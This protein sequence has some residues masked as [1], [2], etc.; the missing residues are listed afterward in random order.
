MC[1]LTSY[2]SLPVGSAK[3]SYINCFHAGGADRR[4]AQVGI[5]VGAAKARF[6]PKAASRFQKDV[7]GGFLASDFLAGDNGAK[8]TPNPY[9]GKNLLD[10]GLESAG[11]NGHGDAPFMLASDGHDLFNGTDQVHEFEVGMLFFFRDRERIDVES[12]FRAQHGQDIARRHAAQLVKAF[13]GENDSMP[14]RDGAPGLPMQGHGVGQ[15]AVAVKDQAVGRHAIW[16]AFSFSS[17][18]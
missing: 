15:S 8:Q 4:E 6:H 16:M 3:Q 1:P 14:G 9:V 7:R 17:S 10:D 13:L 11:S 5:F 2:T 18:S 12:L